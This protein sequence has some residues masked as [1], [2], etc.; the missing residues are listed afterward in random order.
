MTTAA[1]LTNFVDNRRVPHTGAT[2]ELVDPSTGELIGHAAVSTAADV[3]LA[4]RAA[5]S[6]FT[7]WR[8]STPKE[9]QTALLRLA[10]ALEE[11][12][13]HFADAECR[14][15]G[16]PRRV[17]LGEEIPQ[18]VDQLRFFAGAA[19][20]LEGAAAGE[21]LEGTTS[22]IRREPLGVCAQI[23]PW[24]YPLMMA[25]WKI[26]AA[27]AGGNTTV[28]KPA[29]T[30]PTTTVLLAELASSFLPPG[31]LNVV[32]G[33]RDT[34]RA[35]VSHPGAAL[36]AITGSTRAGIEVARTAADDVK[37]T[38]LELGGNAAVL[39][40]DDADIEETADGI[41]AAGFYNAGQDCTAATRIIA[42]DTVHD[43]LLDALVSRAKAVVT[44][45]PPQADSDFGPL[46]SQAQLDRV[47]GLLQ[48]LPQH[49]VIHTGG[50]R[51]GDRGFF[52][53]PTVVSGLSQNDEIIQE[54]LFAPIL[55]VQRFGAEAE[56]VHAANDQPYGLAA[57]VWTRDHSRALRIS[58]D[59]DFGAVWINTHGLLAAEMPHGGFKHSGHGKDLSAYGLADYTRIKHVMSATRSA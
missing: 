46:N 39:V 7:S 14:E 30:T 32:L 27:I 37:Q 23:T 45:L 25:V 6:A 5:R 33:D 55:T 10:D 42:H 28:V 57:S 8:R 29:E 15:T 12:S 52:F 2:S 1:L 41:I 4:L 50:H 56:A 54:E 11:H 31:V 3:D 59:L 17:V 26:A 48:R 44:G 20:M 49:A 51:V 38:H 19:R 18:C 40:F 58:A 24:N 53:A 47:T 22:L 13:A 21:Y 34:G 35:L 36:V 43:A 16:K 9:R